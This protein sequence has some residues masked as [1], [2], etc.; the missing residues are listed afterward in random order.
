MSYTLISQWEL[1]RPQVQSCSV[2][3]LKFTLAWKRSHSISSTEAEEWGVHHHVMFC[4]LLKLQSHK[5]SRVEEWGPYSACIHPIL[6]VRVGCKRYPPRALFLNAPSLLIVSALL[7]P[8]RRDG[9]P[10]R[11][12]PGCLLISL[13][14]VALNTRWP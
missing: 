1:K 11:A 6:A 13:L 4:P 9:L 3:A 7:P 2:E 5:Q 12:L 10:V 14:E 8:G